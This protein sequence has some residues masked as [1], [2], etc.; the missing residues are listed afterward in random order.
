[1]EQGRRA[2]KKG[3]HGSKEVIR[4]A[5]EKKADFVSGMLE[6]QAIAKGG[7]HYAHYGP[8][9]GE[10]DA[11]AYALLSHMFRMIEKKAVTLL[12]AAEEL[13]KKEPQP[14]G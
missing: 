6:I 1:M 14:A 5:E 4:M 13:E 11:D 9:E 10:T 12:D 2:A 7:G 8:D 3:V